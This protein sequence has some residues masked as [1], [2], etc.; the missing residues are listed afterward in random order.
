M[1][2]SSTCDKAKRSGADDA[3]ST[4]VDK[5]K[6]DPNRACTEEYAPVCGCDGV[7]YGNLCEAERA[8]VLVFTAGKCGECI[9][10][11]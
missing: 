11:K 6:A 4:C 1:L 2:L 9:D 3:P 5:K 7:T 8:G 10:P